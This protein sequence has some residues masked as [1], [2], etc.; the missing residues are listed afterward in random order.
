MADQTLE[1]LLNSVRKGAESYRAKHPEGRVVCSVTVDSALWKSGV[2]SLELADGYELPIDDEGTGVTFVSVDGSK[3]DQPLT[4]ELLWFHPWRP[5]ED[6]DAWDQ[7][8]DE[9]DDL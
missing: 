4:D 9:D 7:L 3:P 2:R 8:D 1:A 6:D 5:D